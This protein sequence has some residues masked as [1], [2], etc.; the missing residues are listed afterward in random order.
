M[1]SVVMNCGAGAAG[2]VKG[3]PFS[4]QEITEKSLIMPNGSISKQSIMALI[5]R[6]AEGRTRRELPTVTP[7]GQPQLPS[8][9]M[10]SDPVAGYSYLLHPNMTVVRSLIPGGGQLPKPPSVP[11]GITPPGAGL[12]LQKPEPP[13][14]LGEQMIQGF[15]SKGTRSI[16]T[17]PAGFAGNSQPVQMVSENWCAKA[18]GTVVQ[19]SFSN[20]QIGTVTTKLQGIQQTH[21]PSN[22]FQIPPGYQ[23]VNAPQPSVPAAPSVPTAPAAPTLPRL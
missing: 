17:V 22:L 6:D 12:S 10:I 4:A 11:G 19:S 8:L 14:E 1:G 15:L 18:L 3:M 13:Q 20:P 23:V 21:P 16:T 2:P 5:S 9:T 7:P